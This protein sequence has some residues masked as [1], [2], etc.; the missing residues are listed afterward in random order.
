MPNPWI[1]LAA[2]LVVSG[3]CGTSYHYGAVHKENAIVAAQK[4]DDDL[5]KR[6]TDAALKGAAEAIANIKVRNVTNNQI[7]QKEI[8]HVTDYANCH[9]SPDGLRALNDALTNGEQ[10]VSGGGVPEAKPAH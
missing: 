2:L 5:E 10:P 7:L 6:V 1:I 3:L 9:N 4:R 8:Q